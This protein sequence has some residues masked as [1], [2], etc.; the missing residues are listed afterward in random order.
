MPDVG[1]SGTDQQSDPLR[2][3]GARIYY[4]PGSSVN[5]DSAQGFANS[6]GNNNPWKR[7]D[8]GQG[9]GQ[10]YV[11]NEPSHKWAYYGLIGDKTPIGGMEAFAYYMGWV[12]V[13]T[14]PASVIAFMVSVIV[15]S[16]RTA[17]TDIQFLSA[18]WANRNQPKAAEK[19]DG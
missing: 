11:D 15:M 7:Q 5:Y 17:F 9:N 1:Q 10:G 3:G 18:E 12:I 2:D 6:Q 8:W 19:A 14:I 13:A 4:T 16:L